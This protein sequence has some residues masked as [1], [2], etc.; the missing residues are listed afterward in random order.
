MKRGGPLTNGPPREVLPLP[1]G[2]SLIR[3]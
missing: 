2:A 3:P 1:A